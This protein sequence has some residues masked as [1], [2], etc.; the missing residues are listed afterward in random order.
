MWRKFRSWPLWAQIVA[1]ALLWPV[2][3]TVWVWQ[4]QLWPVWIRAGLSLAAWGLLALFI[5]SGGSGTESPVVLED[6]PASAAASP[7]SKTEASTTTQAATTTE[8][9]EPESP[10]PPPPLLVERVIDGDTIVVDNGDRIRL[11]QIDAPEAK[12]E[13][14]GSKAGKV[15]RQLLPVGAQVRLVRDRRLDDVDRYGRLLRYVFNNEQN[16]NLVLVR[17][18]AA[19]VWYFDGDKGRYAG[20]LL[21]AAESARAARRG[22]WGACQATLDP[23]GAFQTHAKKAAPPPQP[24][25][26]SA[27][28]HPSYKGACLDPSASDYDCEGGS[29][30]GPKYTGL[31]QVVGYDE[32]GL[33]ADSDG[34]GCE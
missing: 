8:E 19:S 11:V 15:L 23:S 20:K 21:S 34:Y 5:F 12:G 2:V 3:W 10:P 16:V 26:Q 7:A 27:N 30:N 6:E 24:V 9:A 17:K 14:Y 4:K 25:L 33:D 28:C 18:G 22:A 29:G 32:Y 13:C 1:W 31:V